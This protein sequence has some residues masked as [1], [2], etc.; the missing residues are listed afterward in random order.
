VA[1]DSFL[2]T[3]ELGGIEREVNQSIVLA[4]GRRWTALRALLIDSLRTACAA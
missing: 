3:C 2:I 4:G 1:I